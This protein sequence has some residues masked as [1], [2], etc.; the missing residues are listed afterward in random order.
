M[1]D[2]KE[3]KKTKPRFE[4]QQ[5]SI[6][7]V[8]Q[9]IQTFLHDLID[10]KVGTD[11][12]G[13]IR[14]ILNNKEMKGANAWLLMCSIMVASLGLDLDSPAVIIGAML[15]SPLMAPILGVGLGVAINDRET[16]SISL[17]HFSLAIIIALFTSFLY[18]SLTPF[19]QI[20]HEIRSRTSPNLLDGLVAIFGGLAGIIS[21]TRKDKSNAIPG[22]AIATALMPPLC[23][24]G[25]GLAKGRFDFFTNA[26]YLF[27]L[28]SFFIAIATY[29]VIRVLGFRYKEYPND[30][31]RK[32]NFRFM[33]FFS[34]IILVPAFILLYDAYKSLQEKQKI[35]EFIKGYFE[36]DYTAIA[37]WEITKTDSIMQLDIQLIGDPVSLENISKSDSTLEKI[38][39]KPIHVITYQ[40]EE[41]PFDD[42]QKLKRD[43][44]GFQGEMASKIANLEK[45]Q[46]EREIKINQLTQELD[47][48]Q[49]KV[50]ISEIFKDVKDNYSLI[51]EIGFSKEFQKT[52]FSSEEK[53]PILLVKWNPR[54]SMRSR[55]NDQ[56]KLKNFIQRKAK[57]DTLVLVTY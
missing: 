26:F 19:G 21:I 28:N 6:Q 54:K 5:K 13:S 10:I 49:N 9:E 32:R 53:I 43:I 22:V 34:F 46:Q 8:L 12:R 15:I 44:G 56:I 7:E 55:N 51:D 16:L 23:V 29:I 45:I 33:I 30:H 25:F 36:N 40:S 31:E 3:I 48:I 27:F 41:I 50:V 35:E 4:W 38:L 17:K 14:E 39:G 52:N 24:A 20:T 11:Q 2:N 1:P 57:L 18:F 37:D 42:I 47:S